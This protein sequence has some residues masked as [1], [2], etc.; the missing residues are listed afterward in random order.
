MA[1]LALDIFAFCLYVVVG[2]CPRGQMPV[3][4]FQAC[5][6][7]ARAFLGFTIGMIDHI[8]SRSKSCVVNRLEI[9]PIVFMVFYSRFGKSG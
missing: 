5:G 9:I 6:D 1:E 8:I 7:E 4:R 2:W 3:F